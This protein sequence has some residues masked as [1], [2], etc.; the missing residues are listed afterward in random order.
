MLND[1]FQNIARRY[2]E[3]FS[4]VWNNFY[5]HWQIKDKAAYVIIGVFMLIV[6]SIPSLTYSLVETKN[7]QRDIKCLALNI[8]HE[9][10]GETTKGQMAVAK[11]T[12]NR[13]A[14]KRYPST[15]CDVVYEKR[16]DKIRK[17]YIGAFSWTEF[18]EPPKV[19]SKEWYRAWN[20]AEAVYNDKDKIDLSGALFYHA[21]HIKPSWAR[22]KKP[23][24]RIGSHVF[25]K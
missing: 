17:R 5:F 4:S 9:A 6:I 2:T 8:Y 3:F 13:V 10:R 22:K 23:V 7:A 16:W 25:Y 18:D 11:V 24:K 19:K 12:L 21:K 1:F 15:V 14:S 20:V